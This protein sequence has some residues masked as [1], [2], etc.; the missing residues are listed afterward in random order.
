LVEGGV[1]ELAAG[2]EW[3]VFDVK[4]RVRNVVGGVVGVLGDKTI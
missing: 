4:G 3:I 1:L 2:R